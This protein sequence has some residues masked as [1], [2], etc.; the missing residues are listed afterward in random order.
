MINSYKNI[1]IPLVGLAGSLMTV[2]CSIHS[3]GAGNCSS[4]NKQ[5]NILFILADDMGYG[6]LS[7]Y[8]TETKVPTPNIDRICAQGVKM[9]QAYAQPV[10]SPTR[11]SFLT[12][13]FPQHIGVYGNTDGTAPGIGKMRKCFAEVLQEKGYGTAWFGKWHQGWD[14]SNHPANN[15]FDTTYGFLGGMHDY[16]DPSEGSHYIGGPF[17]KNSYVFNGFKPVDEMKYLTEELTDQTINFI[18]SLNNKKPF[19]AFLSYNAPH[20]PFQAPEKTVRKYL[21]KGMDPFLATRCAMM[22]VLDT[23]VGRLLDYLEKNGMS[24]KT[25]V[26]F[27]S[28]NGPEDEYNCGGLRG[29]KFT[30]WEGGVRV[31]MIVSYPDRIPAGTVSNSICSITDL[32][33]TFIGLAENDDHYTYGDGKNLINWYEGKEK[34]NVHENLVF[35]L[36]LSGKPYQTPEPENCNLFAVRSGDW[37]LV[38]DRKRHIDELYNL[39]ND[40]G[41][42]QDLSETYP[43]IRKRL[44]EYGKTYLHNSEPSC[45]AI[46]SLNTRNGG[47]LHKFDSLLIK[48]GQKGKEYT[49]PENIIPH[50]TKV[51]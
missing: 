45:G 20:T 9:T 6:E 38:I 49:Y 27:M 36:G 12:G 22:D 42:H 31:P 46:R 16:H 19:F 28:D 24:Q 35:S 2:G 17:A 43:E 33:A 50:K 1:A 14:V 15:G 10:S 44:Y 37:K 23:Q 47:D 29:H 32:A 13:Y 21:D 11:S 26:I 30:G 3:N 34:G 48:Y 8:N 40:I 5:P 25:M 7:C 41:E 39:K 18:S 51:L 4:K